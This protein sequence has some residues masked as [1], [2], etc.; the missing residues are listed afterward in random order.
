MKKGRVYER[1]DQRKVKRY[2]YQVAGMCVENNW[3]SG[4]FFAFD[5]QAHYSGYFLYPDW[6]S[7]S[8]SFSG[9]YWCYSLPCILRV[10]SSLFGELN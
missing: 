6:G 1:G 9:D 2:C 4:I 3:Y 10:R 7:W 8:L 5:V